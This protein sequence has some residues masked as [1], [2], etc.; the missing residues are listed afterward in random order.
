MDNESNTFDVLD[1][2][3][4]D[5]GAADD[6]SASDASSTPLEVISV[7]ELLERLSSAGEEQSEELT[8]ETTEPEDTEPSLSDQ[9]YLMALDDT[10]STDTVQLL[11]EIRD[12]LPDDHPLLTTDFED[13]TVAEGLL[14]S[15]FLCVVG[16]W[17]VRMIKG[18]FSWLLS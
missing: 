11:T 13:Y 8:E 6:I 1:T 3:S 10:S 12:A 15:L 5:G 4:P 2:L 9:W 17:C 16:S 14:L 7:D 18:G